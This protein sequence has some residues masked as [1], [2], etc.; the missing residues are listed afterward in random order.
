MK[1][2]AMKNKFSL[3]SFLFIVVLQFCIILSST[4]FA[5]D[6]EPDGFRGLKWGTSVEEFKKAYPNATYRPPTDT[7]LKLFKGMTYYNVPVNGTK[8]SG[9]MIT[10]PLK[11]AF[12]NN[13]LESVYIDL[14]QPYN[15]MTQQ[16]QIELLEKMEYMYGDGKSILDE[17]LNDFNPVD[18]SEDKCF[19]YTWEGYIANISMIGTYN[20]P[21]P[22]KSRLS[23]TVASTQIRN[24]RLNETR[25]AE[26][27][28][29]W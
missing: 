15:F 17:G 11:Y 29:G 4:A 1:R 26:S 16:S 28:S 27:S 6:N 9:V 7:E 24:K 20:D 25:M 12:Y 8:L 2:L 5:F 21:V 19:M 10:A 23:V 18:F 13:R 22:N 14:S 3:N